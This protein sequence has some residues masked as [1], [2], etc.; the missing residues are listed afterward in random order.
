MASS[1]ERARDP[2]SKTFRAGYY[3]FSRAQAQQLARLHQDDR[4]SVWRLREELHSLA[5][6]KQ[7]VVGIQVGIMIQDDFLRLDDLHPAIFDPKHVL[8][9]MWNVGKPTQRNE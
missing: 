7:V 8:L 2:P 3:V 9:G 5:T 1:V 6:L 4:V